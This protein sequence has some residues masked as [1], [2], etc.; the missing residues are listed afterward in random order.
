MKMCYFPPINRFLSDVAVLADWM[1]GAR[2]MI[3]RWSQP[4]ASEEMDAD[5]KR[6]HY[7]QFVVST[8][9]L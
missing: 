8:H 5:Q 2:E 3:D 1:G 7:L 4:S 6:E 9:S